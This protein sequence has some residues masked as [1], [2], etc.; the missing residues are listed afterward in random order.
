[1][2]KLFMFVVVLMLI[3]ACVGFVVWKP[4]L[5]HI[6]FIPKEVRTIEVSADLGK[7][8]ERYY[9]E[10]GYYPRTESEDELL[11]ILISARYLPGDSGV[12]A[13]EFDYTPI[14]RG[15]RYEIK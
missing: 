11:S 2:R 4:S 5:F 1:M 3:V 10:Y 8:L 6:R 13:G 9:D 15:Q 12:R 14:N 7:A